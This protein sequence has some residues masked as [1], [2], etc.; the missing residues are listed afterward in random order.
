MQDFALNPR[1]SISNPELLTV[2]SE[3]PELR[4][5]KEKLKAAGEGKVSKEGPVCV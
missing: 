1:P 3:L 5:L 2:C 4:K